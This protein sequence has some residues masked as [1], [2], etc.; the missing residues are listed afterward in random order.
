MRAPKAFI[1]LGPPGSGKDTQAERFVQEKGYRQVPSS[2]LI[3]KK[4]AEN[5]ND[6]FIQEQQRVFAAGDLNDA[7][8]VAHIILDFVHEHEGENLVFSGSPRTP[9][10]AH[11]EFSE[12]LRIFGPHGV[13][14]ALLQVRYEE[15]LR[16]T[17]TRRSCRAH[18]HLIP[19][20]PEF[21]HLTVCPQDGASCIGVT[22]T[23]PR[24]FR[25]ATR[26]TPKKPCRSSLS[27][28]SSVFPCSSS[29]VK[30]R[31]NRCTTRSWPSRSAWCPPFPAIRSAVR[32]DLFRAFSL[33][34]V[35]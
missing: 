2:A 31:W 10:E 30:S 8:F 21:A 23:T 20:A 22:S 24:R 3:R 32:P 1:I 27:H 28:V 4:F 5:P 19:G 25:I 14:V 7:V 6:P 34:D 12:F 16:R 17:T 15:L 13:V 35:V 26:N 18:D 33:L 29:M 11:E 9:H